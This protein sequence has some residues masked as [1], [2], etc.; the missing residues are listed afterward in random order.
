M[1]K[2]EQVDKIISDSSKCYTKIRLWDVT[3]E[4]GVGYF[5]KVK[6][7]TLRVNKKYT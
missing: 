6:E 7:A 1:I 5:G 2:S 3:L 4:Q